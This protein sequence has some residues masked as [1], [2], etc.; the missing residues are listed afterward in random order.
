M[1]FA[2]HLY[3][4]DAFGKQPH[5]EVFCDG[6]IRKRSSKEYSVQFRYK[7]FIYCKDQKKKLS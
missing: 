1:D 7:L 4:I 6:F 3:S 2:C 5:V